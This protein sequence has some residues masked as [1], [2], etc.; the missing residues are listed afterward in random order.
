LMACAA[1]VPE[2]GEGLKSQKVDSPPFTG[3]QPSSRALYWGA[4]SRY[5]PVAAPSSLTSV[6]SLSAPQGAEEGAFLRHRREDR[7]IGSPLRGH[8]ALVLAPIQH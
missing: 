4:R 3:Y 8:P 5:A 6:S 2:P 7:D 1:S